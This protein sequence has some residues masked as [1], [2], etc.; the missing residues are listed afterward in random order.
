MGIG[1]RLRA[2]PADQAVAAQCPHIARFGDGG[3]L[4]FRVHI[5]IILFNAVL[6]RILEKCINLGRLKTSEGNIKIRALQISNQQCQLVLVPVTG[7]FVESNVEGLFFFLIQFHHNAFH[8]RDAHVNEHLEPLVTADHTPSGLV[9][10]YRLH[11]AE[12]FNGAFQLFVF[13]ITRLEIL[14]GIVICRE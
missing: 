11:I 9:P 2:V 4:K 5:E 12:L 14:A 1:F 8:F 6:Q 3:L 13:H 7:D 10:D